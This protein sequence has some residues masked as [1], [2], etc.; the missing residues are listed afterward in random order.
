MPITRKDLPEHIV[1]EGVLTGIYNTKQAQQNK[2]AIAGI[3]A[4]SDGN[5]NFRPYNDPAFRG[6]L[7]EENLNQLAI[8]TKGEGGATQTTY[9]RKVA[10]QG[11]GVKGDEGTTGFK[12]VA[13]METDQAGKPLLNDD[14]SARVVMSFPGYAGNPLTDSPDTRSMYAIGDGRL[15]PQTAEV[16]GFVAQ[17]K[18]KLRQEGID[19]FETGIVGHS[20]GCNNSLVANL[21]CETQGIPVTSSL[22]LEP[23]GVSGGVRLMKE[24]FEAP[25][26][27]KLTPEQQALVDALPSVDLKKA[28]EIVQKSADET[29]SVR[30]VDKGKKEL[31]LSNSA[32][33]EVNHGQEALKVTK[34]RN[35]AT[36]GV[37][38]AG[39]LKASFSFFGGGTPSQIGG[40]GGEVDVDNQP[41][42]TVTY[43]DVTGMPSKVTS[44]ATK[45]DPT[46]ACGNM[47]HHANDNCKMVAP[48]IVEALIKGDKGV[49]GTTQQEKETPE[50]KKMSALSFNVDA[51]KLVAD[52]GLRMPD[53]LNAPAAEDS[54]G[55]SEKVRIAAQTT[56]GI[57]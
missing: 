15:Y 11:A 50:E 45:A 33:L 43:M 4:F 48:E 7:K 13:W 40:R 23:V 51:E 39:A 41:V 29:F 52:L 12:A 26:G 16:P 5:G 56:R 17:V 22:M 36:S 24:A 1:V 10:E 6:G 2:D 35:L 47:V 53:N 30:T 49:K 46:H 32:L 8:T 27:A 21:A 31:P 28:S 55:L 57:T 19:N 44:L 3:V 34:D 25:E 18:D 37:S 42:G 20:M 9:Y 38:A 14:G 54:H